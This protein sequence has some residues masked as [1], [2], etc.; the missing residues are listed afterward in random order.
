[1]ME[2]LTGFGGRWSVVL[3][4]HAWVHILVHKDIRL[5]GYEEIWY[6]GPL[7]AFGAGPL[8]LLAIDSCPGPTCCPGASDAPPG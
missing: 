8:F 1:M 2:I 3:G 6:D 7:Y 4:K 5:W